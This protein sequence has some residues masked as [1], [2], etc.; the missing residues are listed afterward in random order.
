MK[1]KSEYKIREIAGEKIIVIQGKFGQDMTRIVSLN[2]S[3]ELLIES[4][5]GRDFEIADAAHILT[6]NYEVDYGTA[7][8]DAAAWVQK[9]IECGIVES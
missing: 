6:E 5:S 8:R 9:L 2:P 7:E 1:I 3:S 4:L